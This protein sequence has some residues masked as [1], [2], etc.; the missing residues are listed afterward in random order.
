MS[1]LL[2]GI[3][4]PTKES[5]RPEE[6]G[7]ILAITEAAR[8]LSSFNIRFEVETESRHRNDCDIL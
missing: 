7:R 4:I 3:Y 2:I 5:A 1:N 8:E 6:D